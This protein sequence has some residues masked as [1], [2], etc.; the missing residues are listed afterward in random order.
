LLES[1]VPV[2]VDGAIGSGNALPVAHLVSIITDTGE[3]TGAVDTI[4]HARIT[5]CADGIVGGCAD[6]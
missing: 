3:D 6:A 4:R 5:A 2:G 1:C